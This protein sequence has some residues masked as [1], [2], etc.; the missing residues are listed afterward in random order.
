MPRWLKG[1]AR[2]KWRELVPELV[3]VGIISRLDRD[4]LTLYC[5]TYADW[6]EIRKLRQTEPSVITTTSGN[7]IQNPLIGL[8][9][10]ISACLLRLS[11][12][13]GLSPTA[14]AGLRVQP[15]GDT[16]G[17]SAGLAKFQEAAERQQAEPDESDP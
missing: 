14:R 5:Q 1:D 16:G 6:L 15:R 17:M 10:R 13:L 2:R 11:R 4:L 3:A 8:Q 12:E 9:N 7:L